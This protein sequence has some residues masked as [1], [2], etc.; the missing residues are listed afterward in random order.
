[1]DIKGEINYIDNSKFLAELIKKL[2]L[3]SSKK[4]E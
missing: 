3:N 1:V 2:Y 4:K